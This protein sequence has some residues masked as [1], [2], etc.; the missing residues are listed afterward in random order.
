[1]AFIKVV[2]KKSHP[3]LLGCN[4]W[5]PS[6][7]QCLPAVQPVGLGLSCPR[8]PT[9]AAPLSPRYRRLSGCLTMVACP[10]SH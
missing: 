1:M 9:R 5:G 7:A 3:A 6:C 8:V 10:E 4:P 2:S